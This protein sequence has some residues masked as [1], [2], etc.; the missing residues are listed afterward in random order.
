MQAPVTPLKDDAASMPPASRKWW[1]SMCV[2]ERR[3]SHGL[4]TRRNH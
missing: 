4:T 1:T 3:P 2:T